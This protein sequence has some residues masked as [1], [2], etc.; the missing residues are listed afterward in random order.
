MGLSESV[1]SFHNRAA[2]A[3]FNGSFLRRAAKSASVQPNHFNSWPFGPFFNA[4]TGF[5]RAAAVK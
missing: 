2:M 4:Q 3:S 1:V 5:F